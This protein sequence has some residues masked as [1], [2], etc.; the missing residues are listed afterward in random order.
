M[1]Y[2]THHPHEKGLASII[3]YNPRGLLALPFFTDDPVT[4]GLAAILA[5]P[6]AAPVVRPSGF[7]LVVARLPA[8]PVTSLIELPYSR[9]MSPQDRLVFAI[10]CMC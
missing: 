3:L 6:P 7:P 10:L 1:S 5:A 4:P 8:A 2:P 9:T